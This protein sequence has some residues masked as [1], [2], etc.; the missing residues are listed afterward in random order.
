MPSASSAIGSSTAV[1]NGASTVER[2][3]ASNRGDSEFRQS[4]AEMDF[5]SVCA[6]MAPSMIFRS[7]KEIRVPEVVATP[8]VKAVTKNPLVALKELLPQVFIAS[9]DFLGLDVF[10]V[11]IIG[12]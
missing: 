7:A 8:V 6:T 10:K 1:P 2:R 3:R 5:P 4:F 9:T 12:E 11:V